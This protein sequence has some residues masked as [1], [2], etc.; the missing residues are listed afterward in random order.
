MK[1]QRPEERADDRQRASV[2]KE[3]H[4]AWDFA[5]D[6][7]AE[8]DRQAQQ[9]GRGFPSA[10]LGDGGSSGTGESTVERL[11]LEG[12]PPAVEDAE[13]DGEPVRSDGARRTPNDP[14]TKAAEWLAEFT[15][16]RAAI[17]AL[18]I[19]ARKLLP[20]DRPKE[21]RVNEVDVCRLCEMPAP[22]VR[23]VDGIPYCATSCF[24]K[25]WRSKER[26]S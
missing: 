3:G 19:R 9:M 24:Y 21:R 14:G 7:W 1:R 20:E 4:D 11:S 26:A 17:T 25:V 10:T 2:R 5:C 23:R 18:A 8:A 13:R 15:E 16:A 22:K 12:Y 6:V